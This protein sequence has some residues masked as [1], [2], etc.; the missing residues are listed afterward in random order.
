VWQPSVIEQPET[1]YGRSSDW[2]DGGKLGDKFIQGYEIEADSYGVAKTAALQSSDD[3]SIHALL[4][5]PATFNG[6]SVRSFSCSPFVSHSV[7]LVSSDGVPWAVFHEKL[8]GQPWPSQCLNWQA[9]MTSLGMVGWGHVREMNIAHVST[10]DLTLIL[11]FD[12]WPTIT[13]TIPNSGGVQNKTKVTLPPNKFKLIGL[14]IFSSAKFR[15]FA[16]D[17]E[18]KIKHWGSTEAYQ[19]LR[20]FGGASAAGAIV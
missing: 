6:Q 4:E 9:E 20:P 3:L 15:L 13:L 11:T 2:N 19:I 14:Q 18:L 16:D 10:A 1:I 17:L 7:R 5:M 12:A 8:V